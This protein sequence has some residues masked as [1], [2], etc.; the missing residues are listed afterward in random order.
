[1]PVDVNLRR[2][3]RYFC[4]TDTIGTVQAGYPARAFSSSGLAFAVPLPAPLRASPT[5]TLVGTLRAFA[6]DS[7]SYKDST[8]NLSVGGYTNLNSNLI[9]LQSTGFTGITDNKAYNI[10]SI[11][12]TQ[13]KFDAEL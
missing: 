5:V 4:T 6:G 7:A 2:C 11:N 12:D 9:S 13:L 10:M 1:M 8:T 3:Q